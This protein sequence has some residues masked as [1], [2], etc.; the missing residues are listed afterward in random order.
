MEE[1]VSFSSLEDI[2]KH[3]VA[4]VKARG[5]QAYQT[6]KNLTMALSVECAELLEHF[7]WLS[8]EQSLDLDADKKA[9]VGEEISDVLFYLLRLAD[10]LNIDIFDAASRKAVLNCKK[11]PVEGATLESR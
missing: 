7:Q 3:S 11:Y 2:Q 5:W 8:E 1:V 4:F 9:Q 10:V 6:P